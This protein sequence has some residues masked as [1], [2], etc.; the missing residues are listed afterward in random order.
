MRWRCILGFVVVAAVAGCGSTSTVTKTVTTVSPGVQAPVVVPFVE[1][2]TEELA[3]KKV[4]AEGLVVRV[5]RQQQPGVP[6][7]LVYSESPP[8]VTAGEAGRS[9][10][11]SLLQKGPRR[12]RRGRPP[13][14]G[15]TVRVG[16]SNAA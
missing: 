16:T 3:I 6:S 15:S 12:L 11:Q 13:Q 8:E 9:R 10:S 5:L 2:L 4:K 1:G 7:G 14:L